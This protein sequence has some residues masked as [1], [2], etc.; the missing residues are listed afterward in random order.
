LEAAGS[1][2]PTGVPKPEFPA[3]VAVGW[4]DESLVNRLGQRIVAS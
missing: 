4:D 3:S 2:G 1:G